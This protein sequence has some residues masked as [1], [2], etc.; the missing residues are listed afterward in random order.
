MNLGDVVGH[1]RLTTALTPRDAGTS[2]WGFAE[3]DGTEYFIKRHL[4]PTWPGDA[5]PGSAAV[6]ERRRQ[7]CLAFEQ[8]KTRA[9]EALATVPPGAGVVGPRDLFRYGAHYY[10][11]TRK[12]V[13]YRGLVEIGSDEIEMAL[14][15]LGAAARALA[16]VHELGMVH[17]DIKPAN[18]L[19]ERIG[20]HVTL[21][22]IDFDAAFF[23]DGVPSPHALGVEP[24][25]AAPETIMYVRHGEEGAPPPGPAADVFAFGLVVCE[26]LTGGRVPYGNSDSPAAAALAGER[27][28][29][30]ASG[31]V[32]DEVADLVARMLMCDPAERPSAEEAGEVLGRSGGG[33]TIGTGRLRGRLL[34]RP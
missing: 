26:A 33:T 19:T 27:L 4:G 11:V 2:I 28:S 29:I 16:S 17:A 10:T 25:Y 6:R 32:A 7:T 21:V 3:R 30:E 9:R 31:C 18:L 20:D 5:S 14:R 24:A 22:L 12:V 13:P 23:L 1:Y 8:S 15:A 34:A